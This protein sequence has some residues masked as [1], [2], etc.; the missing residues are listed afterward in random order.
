MKKIL[1][2]P[3]CCLFVSCSIF[4]SKSSKISIDSDNVSVVKK[5]KV[6][7]ISLNKKEFVYSHDNGS[8]IKIKPIDINKVSTVKSTSNGLEV[9]NAEL[10]INIRDF[11]KFIDLSVDSIMNFKVN[12][13][14][15]NDSKITVKDKE[16]SNFS[17][18]FL[19]WK[20]I[21]LIVI[22]LIILKKIL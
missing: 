15:K 4:K 10:D 17:F 7:D 11:I 21:V 9:N 22:I 2:L 1:F 14:I 18:D 12:K 20:F 3:L 6:K 5:E 8:F 13:D 19:D 16:N